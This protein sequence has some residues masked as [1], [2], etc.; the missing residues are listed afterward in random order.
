MTTMGGIKKVTTKA[1]GF[2]FCRGGET[3]LK[4]GHFEKTSEIHFNG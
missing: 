2:F 4:T 3:V 1:M